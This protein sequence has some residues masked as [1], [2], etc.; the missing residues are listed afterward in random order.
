MQL[1]QKFP[2]LHSHIVPVMN[3]LSECVT[4]VVKKGYRDNMQMTLQGLYS[5][6]MKKTYRPE[7][8]VI[9][10]FFRFEGESDPADSAI[11]YVIETN[12]GDKGTLIDAYGA[13]SDE[14]INRF[15]LRVK[16]IKKQE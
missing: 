15:L 6:T 2:A 8:I 1:H 3:T 9:I 13:Y 10:D 11:L 4:S 12:D 7:E 5:A 16:G 14:D